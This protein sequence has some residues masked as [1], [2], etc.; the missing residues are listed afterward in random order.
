MDH[1]VDTTKV[2]SSP[3][4]ITCQ[5]TYAADLCCGE[6]GDSSPGR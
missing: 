4:K 3:D 2:I 6:G 1:P 5:V